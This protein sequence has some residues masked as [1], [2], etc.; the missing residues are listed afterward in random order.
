MTAMHVAG[1]L[2]VLGLLAYLLFALVQTGEAA[3]TAWSLAQIALALGVLVLAAI[4]L[5]RYMARVYEGQPTLL[6][7]ALGPIER[8]LYRASGV[9]PDKEMDW[10]AL[11]ARHARLPRRRLPRRLPAAALAGRCCRSTPTGSA[12]SS[13]PRRST[14]RSRS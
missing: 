11:R 10:K 13:R 6:G 9:D 7:R 8:S 14:P 1:A 5:G 2:V 4:P 12:P 3:M